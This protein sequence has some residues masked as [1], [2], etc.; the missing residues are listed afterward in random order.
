MKCSTFDVTAISGTNIAR[1]TYTEVPH[2]ANWKTTA[3]VAQS[4][5]LS[6]DCRFGPYLRKLFFL[7]YFFLHLYHNA[8]TFKRPQIMYHI[9][10]L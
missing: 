8:C 7:H 9:P 3:A 4:V 6:K 2:K 10:S 5:E 1:L